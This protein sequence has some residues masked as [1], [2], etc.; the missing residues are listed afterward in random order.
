MD[1]K[2]EAQSD[3]SNMYQRMTIV[4]WSILLFSLVDLS[5]LLSG[6][7]WEQPTQVRLIGFIGLYV[8]YQF[9]QDN[10]SLV[11][12][13]LLFCLLYI[14]VYALPVVD[15]MFA[16]NNFTSGTNGKWFFSGTTPAVH[17]GFIWNVINAY[18][19]WDIRSRLQKMK[20]DR[21]SS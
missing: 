17:I 13:G 12:V 21:W 7:V 15:Q 10:H 19:C 5:Y 16:M 1:T 6:N 14:V 8:G 2:E 3:R 18:L 11:T 20:D 4:G 9:I